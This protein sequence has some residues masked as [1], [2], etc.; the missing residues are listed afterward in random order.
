[1]SVVPPYKAFLLHSEKIQVPYKALHDLASL[2][3]VVG[4]RILHSLD[5]PLMFYVSSY[6]AYTH[7]NL[8]G[9][10]GSKEH[11]SGYEM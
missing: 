6:R 2:G 8:L 5:S 10:S 1:M 9:H 7:W 4:I 11:F 3:K